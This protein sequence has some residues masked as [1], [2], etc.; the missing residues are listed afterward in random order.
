MADIQRLHRLRAHPSTSDNPLDVLI[1]ASIVGLALATGAI[2]LTLGGL[3]FMM[4]GLGYFLA[5]VAMVVPLAVAIRYRWL[6]RLGL[7]GYAAATIVGW[8]LG[9]P[10]YETAYIAKA[11]EVGL[12]ALLAVDFARRDGNPVVVIRRAI[13]ELFGARH[14]SGQR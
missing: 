3:L 2:H 7:I 5:A 6:V 14:L 4:N 1:R 13:R 10:R 11:I 12:I 9:G 8:Y